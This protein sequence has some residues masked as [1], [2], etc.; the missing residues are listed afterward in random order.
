MKNT[1]LLFAAIAIALFSFSCNGDASKT[2][3][4]KG[5]EDSTAQNDAPKADE[6][7]PKGYAIGETV[8]DFK[9]KNIDGKMVSMAD[10]K[11]A[12]GFVLIFT[13][14]HCP[15]SIAYE[16]RIIALD[17]AYKAKGYPVIAINPNDPS[18]EAAKE[19]SYELMQ[20]KAKDKKFS[21]PYL[22]DEGQNVFPKFAA[23]KTPDCFIVQ[24]SDAGMKLVYKGAFDD[25][26]ELKDVKK[27]YIA[28]ALDA[29]LAGKTPDPAETKAF[30]C[31]IKCNDK[32]KLKQKKD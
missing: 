13:C 9:L 14:N 29:L 27:K 3:E 28:D 23:S 31:S 26:E 18:I 4:K 32:T 6:N 1:Y 21:F 7:G 30:G 19:D 22:F 12:K 10:Y 24:K 20:K 15:Y 25:T 16:D 11:D 2:D 17:K 5:T 8:E